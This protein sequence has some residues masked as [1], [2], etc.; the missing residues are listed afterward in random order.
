MNKIKGFESN[1]G[2][3]VDYTLDYHET[4]FDKWRGDDF[5]RMKGMMARKNIFDF[6][7]GENL[8]VLDYGCGIGQITAWIK[9][10]HGFDINKGLYPELKR[11]GFV[12]HDSIVKI[13]NNYFDEI[14]ISMCLEHIENPVDLIRQLSSKLKKGGRIRLNL[15][16]AYYGNMGNMNKSHNGHYFCWGFPDI[17]YLLNRCGFKVILNK[18]VYRKGIDRFFPVYKYLGFKAYYNLITFSGWLLSHNDFDIVVVGEK[19]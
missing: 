6:K 14:V 9:N 12:M 18:K 16:S 2:K 7:F 8:K 19:L 1:L 10:K 3:G 15:P 4:K 13:P 5:Y 17:N 11:R